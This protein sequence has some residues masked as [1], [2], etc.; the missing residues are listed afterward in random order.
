MV[1][2][3][4]HTTSLFIAYIMH[5]SLDFFWLI[6]TPTGIAG[7]NLVTWYIAWAAVL[8]VISG[9]VVLGRKT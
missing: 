1:W 3:Y 6:S 7:V 8:W 2:V 9:I 5:F 4:D